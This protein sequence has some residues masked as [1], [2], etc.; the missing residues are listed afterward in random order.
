MSVLG[1]L[2]L[3]AYDRKQHD[4]VHV[5]GCVDDSCLMQ[6][7]LFFQICVSLIT[8]AENVLDKM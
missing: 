4:K 6:Y 8:N 5:V 7:M 3:N 1:S 2:T